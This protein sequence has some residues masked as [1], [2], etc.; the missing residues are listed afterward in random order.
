MVYRVYIK[1]AV[2]ES[3]LSIPVDDWFSSLDI[4]PDVDATVGMDISTNRI[5]AYLAKVA[6]AYYFLTRNDAVG[7][8]YK[9][10]EL[11]GG[12]G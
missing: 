4:K 2:E 7:K 5:G 8:E 1:K 10:R 9:R 3:A 6:D 12:R 11:F